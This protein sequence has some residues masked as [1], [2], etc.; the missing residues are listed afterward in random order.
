MKTDIAQSQFRNTHGKNRGKRGLEENRGASKAWLCEP[1]FPYDN[2]L[3]LM[4]KA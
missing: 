4:T 3:C 2:C 1:K